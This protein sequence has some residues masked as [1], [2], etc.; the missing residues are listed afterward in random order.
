MTIDPVIFFDIIAAVFILS[1]ALLAMA[2]SYSHLL[3][4]L[5]SNQ[6]KYNDI[7]NEINQKD[8]DLLKDARQKASDMI[9]EAGKK[10]QQI[11]SDSQ[12]LS[13]DARKML[14][15][16]LET[17]IKHQTSY[18]EKVSLDFLEEYKKQLDSLKGRTIQ[19][20]QNASN[21]IE[22]DA[23]KELRDFDDI[24]AKETFSAQKIVE[25]KIEEEYSSVQTQVEEYKKEMFRKV[26]EEIY[27]I[28]ENISKLAIG[29]NIP[30]SMH[31]ELIIEALEKAKK[32]GMQK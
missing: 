16:A 6:K 10:A 15:E 28:L 20:A 30:M 24:L 19:I 32:D 31:E 9:E 17:L 22:E 27:K 3:R 21:A 26:D 8:A 4:K 1:L 25:G 14:D 18:F 11:I 23:Q 7:L 2:V 13:Q 12:T 5:S 29:K